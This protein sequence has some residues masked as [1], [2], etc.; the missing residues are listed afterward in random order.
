MAWSQ[1][2]L[3]GI[4]GQAS[5][6]TWRAADKPCLAIQKIPTAPTTAKWGVSSRWNPTDL[7]QSAYPARRGYDG[8]PGLQTRGNGTSSAIWYYYM[9]LGEAVV[10]DC[11]FTLNTNFAS[12]GATGVGLWVADDAAGTNET[13]I[14]SFTPG[15]SDARGADLSLSDSNQQVTAQYI[16]LQI[17]GA[18]AFTAPA[19][20]QL[21]LGKQYQLEHTPKDGFDPTSLHDNSDRM[22][23]EGGVTY[24]HTYYRRRFELNAE[25]EDDDTSRVADFVS[26]YRGSDVPFVWIWEP[27]TDATQF[28]YMIREDDLDMPQSDYLSRHPSIHAIEQGPESCFLDVETNG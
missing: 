12:K 22:T 24:K 9:D 28:H 13:E 19:M 6:P 26:W 4:S 16:T 25:F 21:I 10:F 17:T 5:Y 20:G 8:L 3:T 14:A 27:N 11:V 2:A 23:T 15:A 18:G 7:T 1:T